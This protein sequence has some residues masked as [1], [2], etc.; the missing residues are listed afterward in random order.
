M[1]TANGEI[2]E[3]DMIVEFSYDLAAKQ[4]V[5]LRVRHDKTYDF[6]SGNKNYGNAYHVAND[7]WKSIH[8][9]IEEEM[10]RGNGIP[11]EDMGDEVYYNKSQ[12]DNNHT[13]GLRNFHN[14]YVKKRLIMGVSKPD[15]ILIDYA[16]GKGGDISKWKQARIRF[17]LGID[18]STDNI[19][20]QNDGV[21]ARYLNERKQTKR[22]FDA[23]FLP[24]N[25]SLN[26]KDGSAFFKDNE[27]AVANAIFGSAKQNTELG[28]AVSRNYGIAHKGFNVSSCQFAIHYMF[29]NK[30]VLHSFLRNVAEC[31]K[32]DGYFIGTCYDG[33]TVFN[34]LKKTENYSIYVNNK[35]I[36]DIQKKYKQTGFPDD[37]TSIG[38]PI[39]VYQES[40]NK[41]ATEFLVN[42]D[43]LMRLMVDYGFT[44]IS[45]EEAKTMGFLAGSGLFEDLFKQMGKDKSYGEA[46]NMTREEKEIS[47]LNRYFIFRKIHNVNADKVFKAIKAS[48]AIE[49][50][51]EFEEAV[52]DAL[53]KPVMFV[54]KLK[55][56]VL[57]KKYEKIE[58]PDIDINIDEIMNKYK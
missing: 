44:L 51:E 10:L 26:I 30:T 50:K 12:T 42:F 25:S 32:V 17:I 4:W 5:P 6:R 45:V 47:F 15:D 41:Y 35:M 23:I 46:P 3:K 54:K 52:R 1:K 7:N 2:F 8:Y 27:R 24:G 34:K 39:N 58:E 28:K 21:C 22:M 13:L 43:Y 29:E 33:Q 53:K 20:N 55:R 36:L 57:L 19:Y 56:T 40:I 38:Y 48:D 49:D 11:R 16:V 9:P 18:V 37:E 31:T 14:L